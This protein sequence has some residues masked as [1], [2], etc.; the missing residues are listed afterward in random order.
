MNLNELIDKLPFVERINDLLVVESDIFGLRAAVF[1]RNGQNIQL[2]HEATANFDDYS[3]GL[4]TLVEQLRQQGWQ[5]QH[6]VLLNPAVV[7]SLITLP[8]PPKNK[9]SPQQIAEQVKWEMDPLVSEQAR[10]LSMGQLWV[11]LGY[12]TQEQV[13]EVLAVQ[14]EANMSK[15]GSGNYHKFGEQ[16]KLM[17]YVKHLQ[18][19]STLRRQAWFTASGHVLHC[20][21]EPQSNVPQEGGF[22]W[23]ASAVNKNLLRHWQAAFV[24]AGL[25][26]CGV[27]PLVGNSLGAINPSVRSDGKTLEKDAMVFEV[28]A[29]QL[30]MAEVKQRKLT[31]MQFLNVPLQQALSAIS[32]LLHSGDELEEGISL[33]VVD[34]S[35][36]TPEESAT[37]LQDAA[38]ILGREPVSYGRMGD[39]SHAGLAGA[40]RVVM[41]M[42][43][44]LPL[45]M[46]PIGEPAAVWYK[47][48]EFRAVATMAVMVLVMVIAETSLWARHWMI[49]R[50]KSKVDVELSKQRETIAALQ[51][52]VDRVN[53][54]KD[55]IQSS[56][57]KSDQLKKLLTLFE[58]TLPQRNQ[59]LVDILHSFEI[60]VNDD[61]VVDKLT[62]NTKTG[63]TVY[64][65][66][67][68]EA[69]A[70]EFAKRFQVNVHPL[71]YRLKDTKVTEQP[72]RLGL[73]G[74]A[75]TFKV[76]NLSDEEWIAAN[77]PL[78]QSLMLNNGKI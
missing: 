74:Y 44:W 61:V 27:L 33:V 56:Q 63:F 34:A 57:L 24:A 76:T 42:K 13:D 36:Q 11:Q 60:S 28:H 16:A 71:G 49:H 54:L 52:E 15:Q 2:V 67:L 38:S 1:A 23:L 5:G 17:N 62:E 32:D 65:W 50:E 29:N 64:A 47:R 66:A 46:V 31:Q 78:K 30:M 20:G 69:S 41:K 19:D 43:P 4:K 26:L 25:K 77:P 75:I 73:L 35:G 3:E 21:W 48:S 8:I 14:N 39:H 9:L 10:Q 51:K 18:V 55:S 6:A 59:H 53:G 40:A 68:N 37:W 7:S 45:T 22:T 58:R 12:M 70:Q 72:G